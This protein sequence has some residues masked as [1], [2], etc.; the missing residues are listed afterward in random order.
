MTSFEGQQ[1]AVSTPH[2]KY[3]PTDNRQHLRNKMYDTLEGLI[4]EAAQ[5]SEIE[6]PD[7]HVLEIGPGRGELMRRLSSKGFAVEGMDID[8]SC[9]EMSSQ[10]GPC[11]VGEVDD[12]LDCF[13]PNSFDLIVMSHVLEHLPEPLK[14]IESIK[15][16]SRKWL[17]LA[18]PN[19]VTPLTLYK[20]MRG[21][22][23]SNPTH[24]MLWDNSH[25]HYLLTQHAD[26]EIVR[27]DSDYVELFVG[28]L[29][30]MLS[31][32]GILPV[33]SKLE[34]GPLP[35]V[36]PWLSESIIKLCRVG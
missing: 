8:P 11:E 15:Q 9:V 20:S 18:V 5:I 32:V 12:L 1:A 25:F 35:T 6:P 19:P 17:L 24:V 27:E 13:G 30:S 34:T 23:W 33:A 2:L 28:R 14:A 16:V 21:Q 22:L 26:L 7:F 29:R 10:Y 3:H 4:E 36:L 31:T